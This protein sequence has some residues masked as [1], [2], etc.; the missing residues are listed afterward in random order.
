METNDKE[1]LSQV[2][3]TLTEEPIE[4]TVDVPS[5][6]WWQRLL[7]RV[8]LRARKRV[9]QLR[10]LNI[11]NLA[12]ISKLLLAINLKSDTPDL[13]TRIYHAMNDHSEHIE[14][15][16]AIALKN[17]TE[18]PTEKEI[19]FV[20]DNFSARETRYTFGLVLQQMNVQDFML[21]I[22]S[23]RGANILEIRNA[24]VKSASNGEASPQNQGS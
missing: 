17:G 11:G 22:V 15:I 2:A 12:R 21:T 4:L 19:K 3:D 1:T 9:F 10:P 24:S 23:L 13:Q 18:R 20:R 6:K 7:V 14:E 8:G 5:K 16:I